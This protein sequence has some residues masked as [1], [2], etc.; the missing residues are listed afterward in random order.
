V[1]ADERAPGL[2]SAGGSPAPAD[3]PY[4]RTTRLDF[5]ARCRPATAACFRYWDGK[6]GNRQM[7]ARSDIDPLEMKEWLPGLALIDV[8]HLKPE[9]AADRRF[10]YELRYRL[11]G[12]R[13]TMLRGYDVTGMRV[14][15][16]WFGASLDAALENY[17]LVIEQRTPVY[18][19]DRTPSTDGFA[20]EGETL[21][22]PL[23]GDGERVD[24]VLVYQEVDTL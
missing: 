23:S 11:V 4:P 8:R 7:P 9:E 1:L 15:T 10:P 19:W 12:T 13:P 14:E 6:C 3:R 20:R 24:M 17:R 5:L 21:L 22:M 16:G 18:D 2:R